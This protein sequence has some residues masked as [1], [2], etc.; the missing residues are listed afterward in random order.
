MFKLR[1][2]IIIQIVLIISLVYSAQAQVIPMRH[3][4][5]DDGLVQNDVYTGF[6][7]HRGYFWFGTY[8]GISRFDGK[9]FI[10]YNED[11]SGLGGTIVKSIIEDGEKQLWVGFTGGI[12]R[13][14]K[15]QFINYTEKDGLLG[16]DVEYLWADPLRGLWIVTEK[17]VSYFDGHKFSTY[18]V[19]GFKSTAYRMITGSSSKRVYLASKKG[20][21]EWRP[22]RPEFVLSPVVKFD[23]KGVYYN[24]Q[25][26]SLYLI[27]K[28]TLYQ[29]DDD[30]LTVVA[31]SKLSSP[32]VN[33][34][35]GRNKK[36]W[37]N[38]ES[39]VWEHSPLAD[40]IYSSAT[41]NDPSISNI[42][43]DREGNI[44]LLR[45]GGLSI[46]I[47]TKILNYTKNLPDKIVTH[48]ERYQGKLYVAGESGISTKDNN[49][50]IKPLIKSSYVNDLFI[51]DNKIYS[52]TEQN[53]S[54]YNLQGKL[55]SRIEEP[56]TTLLR[57]S[58]G[59]IWV[60]G[61]YGLNSLQGGKL[62][63]ELNKSQGLGSNSIW[64]MMEDSKGHIWVGTEK[65][66]SRYD[67]KKWTH[68]TS[69]DGLSHD[70]IWAFCE[71]PVFGLLLGTQKG[72]SQFKNEKFQKWQIL[73]TKT[74]SLLTIDDNTKLWVGTEKGIYRVNQQNS[75]ELF[76]DRSDGLSSNSVYIN[77]FSIE[78]PH[79]YFGTYNG[80]TRIDLN[81]SHDKT[82]SPQLEIN[83]VAINAKSKEISDLKT[84]LEY[85]KNNFT[86]YFNSIY[87]YQPDSITYSWFL[88][89]FD[90]QWSPK[91]KLN[92][93]VYTNLPHGNY[94]FEVK[95]FA[96]ADEKNASRSVQFEILAPFW[97]T[98]W[99]ITLTIV[100][101]ISALFGLIKF[102]I[103]RSTLISEKEKEQISVL[104]QKQLQL[105]RLKDEFLANTSHELRTPLNAIVGL[106]ELILD[107]ING[108]VTKEQ[109]VNLDLIVQSGKRLTNL[110]N[111]IQDYSKL[112]QGE[113]A[114][115]LKPVD[116]RVVA[117]L[118]FMISKG[119]IGDKPIQLH[120]RIPNDPP[121]VLADENRLQQI[122]LNLVGNA[123]K[124]TDQ[125]EVSFSINQEDEFLRIN[126]NDSGI[127]IP[128]ELQ[129]RIF[130][131][132][133]QADG[134][135]VRE[136]QGTGLGLSIAARL[137]ELHGG[138][139]EVK[140]EL[141]KGSVFSFCL[142]LA[143]AHKLTD[144][145]VGN[146]AVINSTQKYPDKTALLKEPLSDLADITE[147]GA[148]IL[149][150]APSAT[151]FKSIFPGTKILVVDDEH[152]NLQIFKHQLAAADFEVLTAQDGYI[153]L[154][155]IE[156]EKPQLVLLDLMMPRINGYDVSKKIRETHS[157]SS[158]PI[159]IIT[160]KNQLSDL[161]KGFDSGA[162]DYL[163]KPVEKGELLSRIETQLKIK[164]A[165]HKMAENVRLLTEV[166]E[167]KKSK[168]IISQMNEELTTAHQNLKTTQ[169][170]LIQSQK[171]EAIGT[172]AGGMAHEF[173][174]I[175]G[176]MMGFSEILLLDL[177][178]GSPQKE[179]TEHIY[180]AGERAA[181]LIKQ[182]LNFSREAEPQLAHVYLP[183]VI[184]E[185][186]KMLKATLPSTVQ[187]N[188]IID[189]NCS[190]IYS[191]ETQIHQII[192]NL[193]NNAYQAL[194]IGSGTIE[195]LVTAVEEANELPPGLEATERKYLKLSVRDTGVG[196]PAELHERI[197]EPFF[198]T[199]EPG[200]GT[201]LGLSVVYGI[202]KQL[203]GD[204]TL[205]SSENHGT[206]VS[207]F[208]PTTNG[209][210]ADLDD[211]EVAL[212]HL[213]GTILV[214][215]DEPALSKFYKIALEILGFSVIT[216]NDS[217]QAIKVFEDNPKL[218]DLILT[219][220]TMPEL[221]GIEL[222]KRI[223]SIKPDQLII[224]STGRGDD[225]IE[226]EARSLGIKEILYKPV[227]LKALKE[228]LKNIYDRKTVV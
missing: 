139:L 88:D 114:I 77:A 39:E 146:S 196:I 201:G 49:D 189:P 122:L 75:I 103:Y 16:S 82:I 112:K 211:S 37:L 107:G 184:E 26:R 197:F 38:S 45:W 55:L 185:A 53:L 141:G 156:R 72:I 68:Y 11:N 9:N 213:E 108:P 181:N 97:L 76:I 12:A 40:K 167:I 32:L 90:K 116:I 171:M 6:Q 220:Q 147:G 20:L 100:V 177:Q 203:Q 121:L 128:E 8:S 56:S 215:D 63:L 1:F 41:L 126:V 217:Q 183:D 25:H 129:Q 51:H 7:D 179:Y 209:P 14:E 4:T 165:A 158:L 73:N 67:R 219:D 133:E 34:L 74:I 33:F 19:V 98:W 218:F 149:H 161:M 96:E 36:V 210:A 137:V 145:D 92:Q 152:A 44:W 47:N 187:I 94:T 87:S 60:G 10:T 144:S 159:I 186:I 168:N 106:S 30:T 150:T 23:V 13:L 193:C 111:D 65:G 54:I 206:T 28:N 164:E 228:S 57:D 162:N 27:D 24:L 123:I 79:I 191:S 151:H 166:E 155:L 86:F 17:G 83:R 153:G 99:F 202:V 104:Y 163:I 221:T 199:R 59:K 81:I 117:D 175:L 207:V 71:H 178:E 208:F 48:L 172:L 61:Y 2:F 200:Q 101:V 22:D 170:Q 124:F 43:E 224:I 140:S 15:N 154:E 29:L 18:P 225:Q 204:I 46:I 78:K 222:S 142:S 93:A 115:Y 5:A 119:L 35:V 105:D 120:N 21:Y 95:V 64:A 205:K 194:E 214:V 109:S 198:S 190:L 102:L 85:S 80:L 62:I 182:I 58:Q 195:V 135:S 89:G 138:V 148:E 134:S 91:S 52:A 31:R 3:Y 84:P 127:G 227:N 118:V 66:V 113:L 110:I 180:R 131:S 69:Q 192:L 169:A 173:N 212:K 70:S 42:L 174:N 223:L 216:L 125:G 50:H 160:A 136:A 176:S 143:S 130:E 188:Q 132:F 226:K 157:S